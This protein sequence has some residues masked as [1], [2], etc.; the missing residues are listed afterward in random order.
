MMEQDLMRLFQL[1]MVLEQK[2]EDDS[3]SD[4]EKVKLVD[5]LRKVKKTLDD[6]NITFIRG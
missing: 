1:Q 3:L 5:D 6:L 2:L 4:S